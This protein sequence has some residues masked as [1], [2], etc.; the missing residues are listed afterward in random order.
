MLLVLVVRQVQRALSAQPKLLQQR[1][2][3]VVLAPRPQWKIRWLPRAV[4][5]QL[6][7]L[8]VE[9]QLVVEQTQ[10]QLGQA[11]QHQRRAQFRRRRLH[12]HQQL[13][14]RQLPLEE[15]LQTPLALPPRLVPSKTHQLWRVA[16]QPA[17]EVTQAHPWEV[18]PQTLLLLQVQE[19]LPHQ[20]QPLKRGWQIRQSPPFNRVLQQLT[21]PRVAM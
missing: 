13:V 9:L 20:T 12:P 21:V 8:Q 5:Q 14:P 4:Q 3:E 7:P 11:E 18:P 6:K 15:L 10:L 16:Q 1:V 2:L 17:L 19:E